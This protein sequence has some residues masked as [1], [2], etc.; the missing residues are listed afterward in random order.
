[1]ACAPEAQPPRPEPP[2]RPLSPSWPVTDRTT[3]IGSSQ[4]DTDPDRN[5]LAV[6]TADLRDLHLAQPMQP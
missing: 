6:T 3:G 1:M 4:P 2:S 5:R